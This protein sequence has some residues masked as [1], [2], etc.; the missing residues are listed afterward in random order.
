MDVSRQRSKEKGRLS[1]AAL[2]RIQKNLATFL[3]L[4]LLTLALIGESSRIGAIAMTTSFPNVPGGTYAVILSLVLVSLVN[5]LFIS[6][7]TSVTLLRPMHIKHLKEQGKRRGVLLE[8]LLDDQDNAAAACQ[9]GSDISRL[10]IAMLVFMLA[11]GL[12]KFIEASWH[13]DGDNYG[14]ILLCAVGLLVFPVGPL[15]LILEQGFRSFSTVHPHGAALR[16]YRF[17]TVTS[18]FL[19]IPARLATGFS[20]LVAARLGRM[21]VPVTNQA[22]EE[23]KTIVESAEESGEIEKDEREL[24]HSVFEFSDTVA[25]EVMTP[26][27]DLDA[28][29]V[30][31]DPEEVMQVIK[32]S[33]H[34]R[35]PLYD[36]TDDQI[37]GIIH[38]KDLLLAM[39]NG[40]E[41]NLRDLMRRP[42][43]VPENK[44]LNDLLTEMR[45][46]RTQIAI[47]NDEFGGT[48]GIVTIEDIVEELVGDIVDEYDVEEPELEA[49]GRGWSVDGK[50]HID[51][52]NEVIDSNFESSEFDTIGGYVFGHFGRQPREGESAEINGYKFTVKCTD[53]RRLERLLVEKVAPS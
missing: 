14:N 19:S 40:K 29:P 31:S 39:V 30:E 47:V 26:R 21:G 49:E 41:P 12:A 34:S 24:L 13:W 5:G 16:L 8:R 46:S 20:R 53:G 43:F 25:R 37:V 33:G 32:D 15:V 7:E 48:A 2:T 11:P 4:S 23:I 27:V 35:I 38:A 36:G 1:E 18:T 3:G 6:G 44:A 28:M 42:I 10:A 9:L 52:L 45:A 50:M 17:I 51:D 22:E